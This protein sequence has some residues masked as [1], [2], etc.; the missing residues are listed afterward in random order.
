MPPE[1]F[2][3]ARPLVEWLNRL[4]VGS[5]EHPATVATYVDEV[6]VSQDAEV[7]R[8]GGLLQPQGDNNVSD[9][10]FLQR[11]IVQYFSPTD[12][13]DGVEDIGCG[14][15]AGHENNITFPYRNMSRWVFTGLLW[16]ELAEASVIDRSVSSSNRRSDRRRPER[17]VTYSEVTIVPNLSGGSFRSRLLFPKQGSSFF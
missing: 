14:G 4:G 12:L 16:D 17:V 9:R 1:P 6:N 2:E 13:G 7:L 15:G 3:S 5:I 8:D 11:E 10:A